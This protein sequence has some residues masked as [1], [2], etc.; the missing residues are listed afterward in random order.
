MGYIIG[1]LIIG[2]ALAVILWVI[3]CISIVTIENKIL[4]GDE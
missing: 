2:L 1:C 3:V 4:K